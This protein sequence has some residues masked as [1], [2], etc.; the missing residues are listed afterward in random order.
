MA[1]GIEEGREERRERRGGNRGSEREK[2]KK[3][4]NYRC[5]VA[6]TRSGSDERQER[7]KSSLG[8]SK[9]GSGI[10]IIPHNGTSIMNSKKSCP[11]CILQTWHFS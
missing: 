2:E 1:Y 3:A 11:P 8:I 6:K 5:R 10:H 7:L 4:Y 9:I